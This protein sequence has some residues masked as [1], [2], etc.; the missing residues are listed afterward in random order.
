MLV[1]GYA[2]QDLE[3]YYTPTWVTEALFS[4]E[5]F[6]GAVLEPSCGAGDMLRV[7]QKYNPATGNDIDQ[8]DGY[9][10]LTKDLEAPNVITNPPYGPDGGLALAFVEKALAVTRGWDGKVAMLLRIDFDS[11]SGRHHIFAG[12]RAWHRKIVLTRRIRWTNIDQKKAGP[13]KNHAW[14]IWDWSKDPLALPTTVY[15]PLPLLGVFA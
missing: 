15:R 5:S 4:V 13:S 11:A 9:D 2:R 7:I 12:H 8:P 6:E 10:F 3:K 14:F 1:S